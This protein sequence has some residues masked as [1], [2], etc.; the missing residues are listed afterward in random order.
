MPSP[1]EKAQ[2]EL[3]K[4]KREF[5]VLVLKAVG[6]SAAGGFAIYRLLVTFLSFELAVAGGI[7]FFLLPAVVIGFLWRRAS[8]GK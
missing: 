7:L 8:R 1:V 2:A 5:W 4:S 6:S 3:A